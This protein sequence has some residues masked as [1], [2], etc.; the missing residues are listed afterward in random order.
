MA[1]K[2]QAEQTEEVSVDNQ[3]VVE[4]TQDTP[5]VEPEVTPYNPLSYDEEGNPVIDPAYLAK[6]PEGAIV[7]VVNGCIRVSGE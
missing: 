5:V 7:D 4:V 1:K 2:A 6:L 3:E